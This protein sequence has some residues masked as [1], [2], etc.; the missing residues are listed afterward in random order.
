MSGSTNSYKSFSSLS[1]WAPAYFP[2]DSEPTEVSRFHDVLRLWHE[3]KAGNPLP[4][5]SSF[6]PEDFKQWFG[7]VTVYKVTLDPFDVAVTLWGSALRHL[8][9]IELT[10]LDLG[11]A[12]QKA[13]F[14]QSGKAFWEKIIFTPM[15]GYASATPDWLESE[16]VKIERIY[17]PCAEDGRHCDKVFTVSARQETS[18]GEIS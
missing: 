8:Y 12:A 3:R 2:L 15:I 7:Y 1:D 9:G 16:P 5:W 17:L 10:G 6:Q 11:A 13:S 14:N 18:T 4:P